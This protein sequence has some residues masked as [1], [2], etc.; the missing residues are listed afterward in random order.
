MRKVF[1]HKDSVLFLLS[2]ALEQAIVA[3]STLW[4]VA[5]SKAISSGGGLLLPFLGFAASLTLVYIP[6]VWR[7]TW[8][9]RAKNTALKRYVGL[10]V[11]GL[12]CT[13]HLYRSKKFQHEK[14]GFIETESFLVLDEAFD[15]ADYFLGL[16]ANVTFNILALCLAFGGG[17][18]LAYLAAAV[19]G[20]VM[21]SVFSRRVKGDAIAMQQA[22]TGAYSSLG[23]AW[24][25]ISLGNS[26][27]LSLW[28]QFFGAKLDDYRAKTARAVFNIEA[29]T[30]VTLWL[31]IIPPLAL[32]AHIMFSGG[33]DIATK[34]VVLAT[35]PRQIQITQYIAD[36]VNC[37]LKL[38]AVRE[39]LRALFGVPQLPADTAGMTGKIDFSR[40]SCTGPGG[41]QVELA[42]FT[43]PPAGRFTVR[44]ANGAGKTTLL[45]ELKN[46]NPEDSVILPA[47]NRLHF[48]STRGQDLSTGQTALKVLEELCG[49]PQ[50]KLVLLDEWDANLDAENMGRIDAAV[51]RLAQTCC[52]VE[53]RHREGNANV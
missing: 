45:L 13:P 52:V 20:L 9:S 5:L 22:R 16:A 10:C 12:F 8:L 47:H 49:L 29:F 35:L 21:T 43:P 4:L 48:N 2:L 15:F 23:D 7:R 42:T 46:K 39:R 36:L 14:K 33:S 32:M 40:T 17:L 34:T 28:Q 1:L 25:A 37:L 6:S 38:G 19:I 51:A 3:S 18:L 27:N 30:S 41:L 26:Y 53:I 31:S 24:D 44:G 50:L 11:E